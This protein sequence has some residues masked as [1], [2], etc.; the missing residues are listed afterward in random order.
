M[1][2]SRTRLAARHQQARLN[3]RRNQHQLLVDVALNNPSNVNA[4]FRTEPTRLLL[5]GNPVYTY[6]V[7]NQILEIHG[8]SISVP[9]AAT[10]PHYYIVKKRQL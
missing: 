7:P 9:T 3:F 2:H 1:W 5:C 4:R 6:Y 10:F 8:A